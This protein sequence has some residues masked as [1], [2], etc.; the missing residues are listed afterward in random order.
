M[1]KEAVVTGIHVLYVAEARVLIG[2]LS[3]IYNGYVFRLCI[4]VL[5]AVYVV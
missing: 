4:A 1:A 3:F 2:G 5:L